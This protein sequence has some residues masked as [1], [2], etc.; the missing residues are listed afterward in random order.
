MSDKLNQENNNENNNELEKLKIE[1]EECKKIRDEYLAGWQRAK[2]DFENYKKDEVKRRAEFIAFANENLINE[3]LPIIDNLDIAFNS[4]PQDLSENL[5]VKGVLNIDI[6]LRDILKKYG[7]E[8]IKV[9]KGD[10]FDPNFHEAI[11]SGE[12]GDEIIEI[13]QKGYLL[14]GRVLRPVRVKIGKLIT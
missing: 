7:I 1:L 10:K 3:I 12:E 6:Q 9:K 2:A 13:F 14:N 5:W 11:T 4:L 8:E